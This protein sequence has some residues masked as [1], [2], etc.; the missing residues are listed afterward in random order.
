MKLILIAGAL[1]LNG[2]SIGYLTIT[3]PSG[4]CTTA[5][6][7]RLGEDVV[8]DSLFVT[9]NKD[10]T[11]TLNV[12]KLNANQTKGLDEANGLIGT[13]AGEAIKHIVIP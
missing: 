2:C 5:W 8:F 1:I 3:E 10:G 7:A 4:I 11:R 13:V 9:A 12:G 6:G